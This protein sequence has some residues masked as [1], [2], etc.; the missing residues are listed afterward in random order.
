MTT[1]LLQTWIRVFWRSNPKVDPNEL[2]NK[3][4]HFIGRDAEDI[5]RQV[6]YYNGKY[7][8]IKYEVVKPE[9]MKDET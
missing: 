1:Q 5:A 3:I 7:G 4:I 9:E 2:S 6:K 8:I